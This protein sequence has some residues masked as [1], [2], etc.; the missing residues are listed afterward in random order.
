M[1]TITHL[2]M[3]ALAALVLTG[4][5]GMAFNRID[6]A[7]SRNITVGQ[8]LIDLKT[9]HEKGIISDAEYEKAKEDVLSLVSALGELSEDK[10]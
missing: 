9:A 7:L 10:N 2:G 6:V 5:A 3:A 1:K 4:C 8:E